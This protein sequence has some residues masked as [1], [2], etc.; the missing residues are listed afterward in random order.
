M[1]EILIGDKK[2]VGSQKTDEYIEIDADETTT[3][4]DTLMTLPQADI[5]ILYNE[6]KDKLYEPEF[7]METKCPN[8]GEKLVN[9][10]SIDD[11]I[12]LNAQDTAMEIR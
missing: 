7:I 8:C 11:L 9:H 1:K 5:D 10:L 12:F 6:I 2:F 3:L 4:M